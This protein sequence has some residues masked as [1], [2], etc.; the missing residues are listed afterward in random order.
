[1]AGRFSDR[2]D[3]AKL[4]FTS[5]GETSGALFPWNPMLVA[6]LL[7]AALALLGHFALGLTLLQQIHS[8]GWSCTVHK[9]VDRTW[10]AIWP[11]IP[12]AIGS[13]T[14]AWSTGFFGTW[15]GG[16]VALGIVTCLS[17]YLTICVAFGIWA[18]AGW[19][20]LRYFTSAPAQLVSEQTTLVDLRAQLGAEAIGNW[21]GG[22]FLSL[23]GNESLELEVS[24]RELCIARLPAEMDGLTIAHLSDLHYTGRLSPAYYSAVV[25]Q[26]LALDADL[27]VL[28]GDLVEEESC[29]AWLPETLGR[30]RA[31]HGVHFILGNH[32]RRLPDPDELRRQLESLG[33]RS[34]A[35]N[36]CSIELAE[37]RVI[38]GGDERPWF[39]GGPDSREL[40]ADIGGELRPLR[41]LLAHTPDRIDWAMEAD[42]DLVLAGHTHGGQVQLP[43]IGPIVTPSRYGV[44]YAG[45]TYSV[46]QVLMH[47]TRGVSAQHPLRYGAR[48]EIVKLVLRSPVTKSA[49]IEKAKEAVA[50]S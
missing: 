49:V 17:V 50:A 45:G 38:L 28:T 27:I 11:A 22:W 15:L 24:Q 18:I 30:L 35:G 9:I 46:G 39:S 43:G 47:V 31:P 10:L 1:L 42:I 6:E 36:W 14:I 48:P 44:R 34:A 3:P 33:L 7:A 26:V 8:A 2:I 13:Y 21:A 37:G 40:P 20:Q 5:T 4:R 41:I 32:D 29:L 23:P 25:D 16:F 12:L 19:F